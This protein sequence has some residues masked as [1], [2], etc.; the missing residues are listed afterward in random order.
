[1]AEGLGVV[2]D[3][4]IVRRDLLDDW[5]AALNGIDVFFVGV[6]CSLEELIFRERARRDRPI[7]SAEGA[8]KLVHVHASYDLE[9]DSTTTPSSALAAQVIAALEKRSGPSAFE[10][11][12]SH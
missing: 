8:M 11:L 1:V 6:H 4:A 9:I 10:R 12:R 5:L 7:G 3:D 2:V